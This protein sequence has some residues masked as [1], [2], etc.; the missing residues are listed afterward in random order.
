MTYASIYHAL[1]LDHVVLRWLLAGVQKWF[2][3]ERFSLFAY[4]PILSYAD[5]YCLI[6]S[7]ACPLGVNFKMEKKIKNKETVFMT[8]ID[9]TMRAVAKHRCCA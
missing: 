4:G 5:P 6:E 9:K 1:P 8:N 3:S 7:S 2:H